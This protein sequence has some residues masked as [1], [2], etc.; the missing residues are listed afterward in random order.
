MYIIDLAYHI[1][2]SSHILL[3]LL[4]MQKP[5]IL[6]RSNLNVINLHD[7]HQFNVT[8]SMISS[9]NALLLE[10]RA[11]FLK[12]NLWWPCRAA[13]FAVASYL[14]ER[15]RVQNMVYTFCEDCIFLEYVKP[16]FG[17]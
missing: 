15:T 3:M 5:I 17:R 13:D 12:R 9:V 7:G 16:Y 11:T 4:V 2:C 1:K 8:H 6:L 14:R 10:T